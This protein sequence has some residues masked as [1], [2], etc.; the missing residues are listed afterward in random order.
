[1]CIYIYIYIHICRAWFR[2]TGRTVYSALM[3][4]CCD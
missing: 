4:I 2:E 1:M 3:D